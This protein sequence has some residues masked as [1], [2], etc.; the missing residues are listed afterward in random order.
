M[1]VIGGTKGVSVGSGVGA[2]VGVWI[3]VGVGVGAGVGVA[4]GA[5]VSVGAGVGVA[6]PGVSSPLQPL[7]PI[8]SS[9]AKSQIRMPVLMVD[10]ERKGV[11]K[12]YFFALGGAPAGIWGRGRARDSRVIYKT[13][14]GGLVTIF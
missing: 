14:F 10:I 8:K 4:V 1:V 9:A 13:L 6:S 12:L 2:G 3:G 5:G 11:K 7:N